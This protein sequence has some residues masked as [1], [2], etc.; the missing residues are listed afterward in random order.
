M[1]IFCVASLLLH[2]SK[3]IIPAY[4]AFVSSGNLERENQIE[5][6]SSGTES[7]KN[8]YLNDLMKRAM[9]FENERK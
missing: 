7:L 2:L 1:L 8:I 6:A 9:K 5:I 4:S 3:H